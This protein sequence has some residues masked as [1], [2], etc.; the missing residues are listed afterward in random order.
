LGSLPGGKGSS[1]G[2]VL[3]TDAVWHESSVSSHRLKLLALPLGEA[4]L[5]TDVDLLATGE[6]ELG[7]PQCLDDLILV[8][9]LGAHRQDDL[10]DVHARNRAQRLA[11]RTAHSRLQPISAGAGQHLV[12]ANDVE[13]VQAHSHVERVLAGKLDEVLIGTDSPRLE[14]LRRDLLKLIG[15]EVDAEGKLVDL[16]LFATKVKDADLRVWHTAT[17]ARLGVRLVLA[18][19]VT[20]CGS[21]TH[22]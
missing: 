21:A 8:H 3:D 13:R 15:D 19:P 6:L 7:S 20:S 22:S 16:G 1:V 18:V 11:K 14:G 12:D 10:S 9:V 4:P 5:A 2:L 17:E